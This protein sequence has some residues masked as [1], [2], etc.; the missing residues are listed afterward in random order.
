MPAAV[1][2]AQ[3]TSARSIGTRAASRGATGANAP[4]QRTG[5]VVSTPAAAR[6]EAE[7]GADVGDQ[8]RQPRQHRAQ[9]EREQHDRGDD[10]ARPRARGQ[11]REDRARA[12]RSPGRPPR[13]ARGG[14]AQ[15]GLDPLG[16]GQ[17]R[18]QQRLAATA[19]REARLACA[20]TLTAAT[21]RAVAVADRRGDRAQALLE[22]LVDE[23]PALARGRGR[24]RRAARPR[25]VIVRGGQRPQLGAGEVG[26]ELVRGQ[27][28]RAAR[29]P[30]RS[31][32]R[33]SG[34]RR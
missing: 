4:M 19:S 6:R 33:G 29:A 22:L 24:A 30:S 21:T 5:S 14:H 18:R 32:R 26:V 20:E 16:G 23:R 1:S 2:S 7:V 28:R 13:R 8:R 27:R 10:R 11:S 25:S 17:Q 9:V 15:V 3:P 34:C 31:R 12:A